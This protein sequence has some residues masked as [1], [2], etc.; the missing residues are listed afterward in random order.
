MSACQAGRMD[1]P[2]WAPVLVDPTD[3]DLALR[4]HRDDDVP[5]IVEQCRDP[6]SQRW[7]GV[8]QPYGRLHAEEFVRTRPVEWACGRM[9][10]LAVELEGRFAGTVG[11][12]P[13][14]GTRGTAA[15]LGYG[16]AAWAR[17]RGIATRACRL[18]L[19][20]A[21]DVLPLTAVRWTAVTGNW[22]SRRVAW[23]L[24]FA[25]HGPIPGLLTHRGRSCEGWLG[26]LTPGAPLL[27]RH[28]WFTP[29]ELVGP[30]RAG[31]T[32]GVLL[33]PH[34]P[35]DVERVVEACSDPLTR[36]WLPTL[37][38]PYRAANAEA[39]LAE[40]REE[41][42]AGRALHW[43]I[44]ESG[45]PTMMGELGLQLHGERD[46]EVGYWAHPQGRGRGL[47]SAA[48]RLAARHALL[49]AE[50]GGLGRERVLI[51]VA[52]GNIASRRVALAAGFAPTG[53]DRRGER[54]RDG[55]T[56]DMHRFDLVAGECP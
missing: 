26:T 5:D 18:L 23:A 30:A 37:P 53:V 19:T 49:P 29:P 4:G 35:V 14:P 8:P 33:R 41:L 34:R 9:L 22:P 28:P 3:A 11:L 6:L 13:V 45:R 31:A 39:F 52:E 48:V 55:S 43:A 47:V 44:A 17:G 24:G 16:L 32:A 51:R 38:D 21:V 56:P 2:A 54:L 12:R 1:L 42:A 46:S 25:V 36:H 7:T 40:C 27:A 15:E 50:D 10:S 20:W